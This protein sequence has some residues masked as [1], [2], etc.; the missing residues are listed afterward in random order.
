M[1]VFSTK[2]IRDHELSGLLQPPQLGQ[3]RKLSHITIQLPGSKGQAKYQ[4]KSRTHYRKAKQFISS[5]VIQSSS[6]ARGY[7]LTCL[8]QK[9]EFWLVP[10]FELCSGWKK[11]Q[12]S[13]RDQV[14]HHLDCCTVQNKVEC[15][16]NSRNRVRSSE[17]GWIIASMIQSNR[18]A[19]GQN[20]A[21]ASFLFYA[22]VE[23][24]VYSI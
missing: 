17:Q 6:K 9:H 18:R 5:R 23:A 24:T 1:E 7:I 12:V 10:L 8:E 2:V 16:D 3:R 19:I 15:C 11:G 22:T 4:L 13:V 21:V 20:Q 14:N